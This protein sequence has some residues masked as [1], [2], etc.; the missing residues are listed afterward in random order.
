MRKAESTNQSF[1]IKAQGFT[2][3]ALATALLS[4]LSFRILKAVDVNAV[5]ELCKFL[6]LL[7]AF[8]FLVSGFAYFASRL[9]LFSKVNNLTEQNTVETNEFSLVDD[10]DMQADALAA[11][12][13]INT[14]HS[15]FSATIR[16]ARLVV[17]LS[18]AAFVL[19]L[20]KGLKQRPTTR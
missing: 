5:L 15:G 4:I 14:E 6:L 7:F 3:L 10:K 19:R 2:A 1:S 8:T 17:D 13:K 16:I 11:I 12:R 20:Y 9:S 18:Y